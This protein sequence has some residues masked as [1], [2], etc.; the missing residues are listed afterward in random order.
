[1]LTFGQEA[2][3]G[4]PMVR[5]A[6][7]A[8]LV[9]CSAA[10]TKVNEQPALPPQAPSPAVGPVVKKTVRPRPTWSTSF[11][12]DRPV[13]A[14]R[15][16]PPDA[17]PAIETLNGDPNGLARE[18]LQKALDAAMP[19]FARCFESSEG[20]VNV[21]LSFDAEPAGEASKLK[22]SGGGAAAERCVSGV[23]NGLRLPTFSGPPVPVHFPLSIQAATRPKTAAVPQPASEPA[24]PAPL[25]VSP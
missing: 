19:A 7:V 8:L 6:L 4:I 18:E 22:I 2:S 15:T 17:R 24:R 21:S 23:V 16:A 14:R 20:S 25:F 1:M 3:D 10:C 13:V 12:S 5:H 9:G 11:E